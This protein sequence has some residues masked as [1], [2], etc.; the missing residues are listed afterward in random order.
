MYGYET[1]W[2]RRGLCFVLPT[3]DGWVSI[4]GFFRPNPLK[5]F[6]A[7]LGREDLSQKPEY[8]TVEKQIAR[9]DELSALLG[10]EVSKYTTAEC[11]MRF[12][13]QDVICSPVNYLRDTLKHPQVA[14]NRMVVDVEVPGQGTTRLVGSPLKMSR[15]GPC[16]RRGPS[17]LGHDAAEVLADLGYSKNEMRELALEG[18]L[19]GDARARAEAV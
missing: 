8:D 6:C 17:P 18:A 7:A 13:A 4:L 3:K 9:K 2:H 12:E 1:N 11:L 5:L 15:T 14:H 16:V 10:R 19:G